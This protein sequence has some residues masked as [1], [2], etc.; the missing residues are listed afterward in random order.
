MVNTFE[1]LKEFETEEISGGGL[2]SLVAG[3]LAGGLIGTFVS[4]PYAAYK[5]DI[6]IVGK[7]AIVGSSAGAYI[8]A[9]CPLP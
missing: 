7:A 3:T 1:D 4:L 9:G 2:A 8:G 5:G 6:R